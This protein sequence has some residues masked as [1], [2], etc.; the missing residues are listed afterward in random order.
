MDYLLLYLYYYLLFAFYR[1]QLQL[2]VYFFLILKF[3]KYYNSVVSIILFHIY[4]ISINETTWEHVKR[5]LINR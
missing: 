4:L 5:D 2:T 1:L 3:L